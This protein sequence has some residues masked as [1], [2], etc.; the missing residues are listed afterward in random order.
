MVQFLQSLFYT[1]RI[2]TSLNQRLFDYP[3]SSS[4]RSGRNEGM[5]NWLH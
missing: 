5:K 4:G 2:L 3:D 1:I